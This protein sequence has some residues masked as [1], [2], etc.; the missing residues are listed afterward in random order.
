M[1]DVPNR[2]CGQSFRLLLGFNSFNPT[3]GQQLP[4]ELLQVHGGQLFQRNVANVRFDVVVDIALVGLVAGWPDFDFRHVLEPLVH[5]CTDGVFSTFGKV[6]L[7]DFHQRF[8]QF[9]LNFCLGFAQNILANLLSGGGVMP[10]GEPAFPSSVFSL[11]DVT[12][13]VCSFLSHLQHLLG[14]SQHYHRRGR[15]AIH[16]I[17]QL[18][19]FYIDCSY[20]SSVW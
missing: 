3:F 10:C 18:F 19:A 9:L 11:S 1:V 4:V 5:P 20:S 8:L 16:Q 6:N 17:Q 12:L 14:S 2:L 13:T 7:P 15:I